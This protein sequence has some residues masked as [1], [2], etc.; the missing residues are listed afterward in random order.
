MSLVTAITKVATLSA[1]I[2][3]TAGSVLVHHD[4][5]TGKD[6]LNVIPALVWFYGLSVVG[7]SLSRGELFSQCVQNVFDILK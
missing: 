5:S 4:E 7:C 3:A 1:S 2:A 6:S